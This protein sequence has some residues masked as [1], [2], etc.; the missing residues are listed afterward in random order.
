[1]G[2]YIKESDTEFRAFQFKSVHN[3]YKKNATIGEENLPEWVLKFINDDEA[4]VELLWDSFG[5]AS[6]SVLVFYSKGDERYEAKDGDY[7]VYSE[8]TGLFSVEPMLFKC[9][10]MH[11]E[12]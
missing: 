8:K 1:M 9:I 10:F 3:S 6:K 7:V 2:Y 12:D 5:I 4:E 11:K